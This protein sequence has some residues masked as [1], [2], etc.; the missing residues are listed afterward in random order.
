MKK[1]AVMTLLGLAFVFLGFNLDQLT[2]NKNNQLKS[3]QMKGSYIRPL[4]APVTLKSPNHSRFLHEKMILRNIFNNLVS[5]AKDGS[6][7]GELA[8][9]WKVSNDYKKF[10]FT[11]MPG[12]VFHNQEK[13]RVQDIVRSLRLQLSNDGIVK[14]EIFS[15]NSTNQLDEIFITEENSFT[16]S[17]KSPFPLFLN[18][19]AISNFSVIS[20][21]TH[22]DKNGIMKNPLGTGPFKVDFSSTDKLILKKHNNYFKKNVYLDSVTLKK[23]SYEEAKTSFLNNK[24]HDLNYYNINPTQKIKN[25]SLLLRGIG[26]DKTFHTTLTLFYNNSKKPFQSEVVRK[27]FSKYINLYKVKE[28]CFNKDDKIAT[29]II[30]KGQLGYIDEE[31]IINRE[32]E[33]GF[34]LPDESLNLY[35]VNPKHSCSATEISKQLKKRGVSITPTQ[36]SFKKGLELFLSNKINIH[37]E[38]ITMKENGPYSMI[39][40]F[41]HDSKQNLAKIHDE[42]LTTLITKYKITDNV[43]DQAILLRQIGRRINFHKYVHPLIYTPNHL[44]YSK[45]VA[46]NDHDALYRAARGSLEV[47]CGRLA[48]HQ[49]VKLNT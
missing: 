5:L 12:V 31:H 49:H 8:K 48:G 25:N 21:Q 16:I 15:S 23:M 26:G 40:Y 19:L 37:I 18:N 20:S 42:K 3:N 47:E 43:L 34:S 4:N 6:I 38:E 14:S 28:K 2:S 17:F 44:I 41:S 7:K 22:I 1:I 32:E 30:P 11:L 13:L 45:K 39:R 29:G 27:T 36:I 10:S 35:F 33:V 24:V 46:T 9:D